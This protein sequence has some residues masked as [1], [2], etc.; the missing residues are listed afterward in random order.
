MTRS[1]EIGAIK[2]LSRICPELL[3]S[4]KHHFRNEYQEQT[5]T[6]CCRHLTNK[7]KEVAEVQPFNQHEIKMMDERE[8]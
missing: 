3:L 5:N 7:I 2:I 8:N 6:G 1:R 4:K